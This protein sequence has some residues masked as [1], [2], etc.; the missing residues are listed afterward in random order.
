VRGV[1]P[2]PARE[3]EPWVEALALPVYLPLAF[4]PSFGEPRPLPLL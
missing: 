1:Q 4:A 2:T 3:M